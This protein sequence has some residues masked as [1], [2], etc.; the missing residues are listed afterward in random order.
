MLI[1]FESDI[2]TAFADQI[3]QLNQQINRK[4]FDSIKF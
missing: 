3:T 2:Y 1:V 4:T